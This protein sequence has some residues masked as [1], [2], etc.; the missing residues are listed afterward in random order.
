MAKND[1]ITF[2]DQ[3]NHRSKIIVDTICHSFIAPTQA[4]MLSYFSRVVLSRFLKSK[5]IH[6][7]KNSANT[8]T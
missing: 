3:L 7:K 6:C 5:H 2:N 8:K 1:Q 4:G